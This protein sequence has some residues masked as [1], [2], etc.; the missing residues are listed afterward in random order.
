MPFDKYFLVGTSMETGTMWI[1]SY[2]GNDLVRPEEAYCTVM[3]EF[4]L[5]DDDQEERAKELYIKLDNLLREYN[6]YAMAD[7]NERRANGTPSGSDT[8]FHSN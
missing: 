3:D 8:V 5:M 4:V 7:Y 1:S 2:V 6:L